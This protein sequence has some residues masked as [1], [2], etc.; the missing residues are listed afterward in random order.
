[1]SR[2]INWSILESFKVTNEGGP[3]DLCRGSWLLRRPSSAS[4]GRGSLSSNADRRVERVS[5][6]GLPG[7]WTAGM[8]R[9][10]INAE[11]IL[12]QTRPE[13]A[14]SG[15]LPAAQQS[16]KRQRTV[17]GRQWRL[18]LHLRKWPLLPERGVR[19]GVPES[20]RVRVGEWVGAVFQIRLKEQNSYFVCKSAWRMRGMFPS[21]V[22][23]TLM[24]IVRL[25][26]VLEVSFL[27]FSSWPVFLSLAHTLDQCLWDMALTAAGRQQRPLVR[28]GFWRCDTILPRSTWRTQLP[29]D[30]KSPGKRS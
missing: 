17:G 30:G 25:T 7:T 12:S 28:H 26:F 24:E 8:G 29:R 2:G 16:A 1:M 22:K 14:D 27:F 5:S 15:P 21:T 13:M 23:P 11:V 18:S 19:L 10:S 9:G 4:P 6:P 20:G 3:R